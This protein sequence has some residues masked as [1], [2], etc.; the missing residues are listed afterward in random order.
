MTDG[1][2]GLVSII[3]PIYN[4]E[5]YIEKCICSLIAQSYQNIEIILVNDGSTDSS[6]DICRKY[7]DIDSRVKY[8]E[9]GNM[10]EGGARNTGLN[11]ASGECICFCDSDDEMPKEAV[12]YLMQDTSS[13]MVAGGYE[14]FGDKRKE[15]IPEAAP[16]G[17]KEIIGKAV[18]EYRPYMYSVCNKKFRKNVIEKN[19]IR[20]NDFPYGEDTYF[21]YSYLQYAND[22]CFIGEVVYHVNEVAGS[23]SRRK[24]YNSWD[25]MREIYIQGKKLMEDSNLQYLL[26][27]ISI[28][29]TLLLELKIEK[30]SF[31]RTCEAIYGFYKG[32]FPG[33]GY[34]YKQSMYERV[35]LFCIEHKRF[36]ELFWI[37]VLRKKAL[38]G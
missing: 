13:D 25:Y 22:I 21:V 26:L 2:T 24:V 12:S 33:K 5:K 14:V 19:N 23:M 32:E 37:V 35:I 6:G 28:K 10:G 15:Y 3:V 1:V 11:H 17:S 8:Y 9:Q 4:S 36:N 16:Y 38:E 7:A 20:F 27:M 31:Y 29:T 30:E 34:K 18:I